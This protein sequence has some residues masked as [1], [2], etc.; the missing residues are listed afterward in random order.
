MGEL[1]ALHRSEWMSIDNII[2]RNIIVEERVLKNLRTTESKVVNIM[3][4]QFADK[5]GAST[6]R[7]I[8]NILDDRT[9]VETF[10]YSEGN[11]IIQFTIKVKK[12]IMIV[13]EAY[14]ERWG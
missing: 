1:I 4:R 7:Q 2:V 14:F 8:E 13:E 6:I 9:F 3:V 10:R 12:S 5:R 11:L